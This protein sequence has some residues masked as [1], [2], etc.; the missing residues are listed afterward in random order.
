MSIGDSFPEMVPSLPSFINICHRL[1]EK[2]FVC[3]YDGNVSMRFDDHILVT[4]THLCKGD[5]AEDDLIVVDLSGA[6]VYGKRRPSSELKV[7]LAVYARQPETRCV[8]H[9]HP[10]YATAVYREGRKVRTAL[11]MEAEMSLGTVPVVPFIAPGSQAL[12][13]AVGEAMAGDVRACV[14]EKHG[15]VTSGETLE[16]TYFLL[17]SLE[18][19]AKTEMIVAAGTL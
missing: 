10:L 14:M 18:R 8:I 16:T 11:L 1:Y 9:A 4:P 15:V 5:V 7:H 12:A 13:D 3:A 19:L 6:Q 17:E 2:E